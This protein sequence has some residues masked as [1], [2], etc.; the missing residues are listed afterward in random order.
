MKCLPSPPLPSVA[1]SAGLTGSTTA[2]AKDE[3]KE[4]PKKSGFGLGSLKKTVTPESQ[5]AQV[6]ASGGSRGVG[7]DRDAKG[8]DNPALVKVSVTPAEVAAFKKGICKSV[9]RPEHRRR[10]A[11]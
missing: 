4:E 2:P 11:R 10:S 8:G 9:T 6:S 7:A 5:S 3:K 1:G